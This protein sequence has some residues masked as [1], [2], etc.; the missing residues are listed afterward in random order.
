MGPYNEDYSLLGS[1]L[2]YHNFGKLL[3]IY[4]FEGLYIY[5]YIYIGLYRNIKKYTGSHRVI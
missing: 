4:A 5:I 2:G 1:I 3:C